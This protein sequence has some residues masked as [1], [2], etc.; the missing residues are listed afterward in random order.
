MHNWLNEPMNESMNWWIN[1]SMNPW[2]NALFRLHLPKVLQ[3]L[4]LATVS[5]AFPDLV[6]QKCSECRCF[7]HY[8]MQIELSRRFYAFLSTIFPARGPQPQKQMPIVCRHPEP[9]YPT[10]TK[11]FAPDSEWECFHTWT[12]MLMNSHT[13]QLLDM[14]SSHDD[15]VDIWCQ[16]LFYLELHSESNCEPSCKIPG[17]SNFHFWEILPSKSNERWKFRYLQSVN[18]SWLEA[19]PILSSSRNH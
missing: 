13:S 1:K 18:C 8:E 2:I 5:C 17:R 12:H 14:G 4:E 3:S 11:G 9:P 10:K 15:V 6:V 19:H 16:L 7:L